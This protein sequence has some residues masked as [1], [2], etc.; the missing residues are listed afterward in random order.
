ML[1][2]SEIPFEIVLEERIRGSRL[3][4]HFRWVFTALLILLLAMQYFTGY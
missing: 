4:V 2:A 3:I 1:K